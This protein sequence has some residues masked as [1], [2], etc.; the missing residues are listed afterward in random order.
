[1]GSYSTKTLRLAILECDVPIQPVLAARGTYGDIFEKVLGASI[2]E[3]KKRQDNLE[4][5]I[6]KWDV[7]NGAKYPN[8]N[9]IDGMLL[10]GSSRLHSDCESLCITDTWCR[11][12]RI[13]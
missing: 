7:V 11:A 3:H 1:M 12:Y 13:Q 5:E 9:E 6:S 2:D 10:T 4:I 8:V